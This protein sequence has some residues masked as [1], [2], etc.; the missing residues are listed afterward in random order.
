MVD[1]RIINI[2]S[3]KSVVKSGE[4][5]ADN[6]LEVELY[7]PSSVVELQWSVLEDAK[8]TSVHVFYEGSVADWKK[9]KKG[10]RE[11][12]TVKHDW[13]G[14]YYH[15]APIEY[16]YEESYTNWIKCKDVSITCKDGSIDDDEEE[17]KANPAHISKSSHWD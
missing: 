8:E 4:L 12:I 5:S 7:I 17:N 14:Y 2:D 16:S 11:D 10:F 9:I 1:K 13:Y 3:G 6:C 15:N